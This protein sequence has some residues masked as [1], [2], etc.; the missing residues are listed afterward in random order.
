VEQEVLTFRVCDPAM[1]SG[2]FLVNAAHTITNFLVETLNLTPWENPGLDANPVTWRRKVA[3]RCLYG[4]D[5]NELAVELAKLS[6]WLT[7]VAK[8][9]PLSFLDHHLRHGN[10]LIG[11]RL[12]DLIEVLSSETGQDQASANGQ[13]SMFEEYPAF[14]VPL[15]EALDLMRDISARLADAAEDVESQAADYEQVRHRLKTF[16]DLAE[17][18]TAQ[19]CGLDV[20]QDRLHRIAHLLLGEE[21]AL[22]GD[23]RTLLSK[24]RKLAGRQEFFHWPLELPEVFIRP[25]QL[26][27]TVA[28]FDV[29]VGNPPHGAVAAAEVQ[30]YMAERFQV[31]RD[32]AV[33]FLELSSQ[34]TSDNGY[35]S[36]VMP[37]SMLFSQSWSSVRE[38]LFKEDLQPMAVLDA[39]R[40]FEGT[41]HEQSIIV[42]QKGKRATPGDIFVGYCGAEAKGAY[43][44]AALV[45]RLDMFPCSLAEDGLKVAES[46]LESA[47]GGV[48]RAWRGLPKR[49][50]SSTG[51]LA[52]SHQQ[53]ER[54]H[55][56]EPSQRI[57]L[58]ECSESSVDR[59]RTEKLVARRLMKRTVIPEPQVIVTCVPDRDGK[60]TFETVENIR[61]AT[62]RGFTTLMALC[63]VLNSQFVRW[64]V[65]N[66]VYIRPQTSMDFDECYINKIPIPSRLSSGLDEEHAS[67]SPKK[68]DLIDDWLISMTRNDHEGAEQSGLSELKVN[69]NEL[70]LE[71]ALDDVLSGALAFLASRIIEFHE[72]QVELVPEVDLLRYVESNQPLIRLDE[73]F[74]LHDGR[75]FDEVMKLES[76]HHD[77]DD[78]RLVPNEDATWTLELQ[79]KFRDP[80]Q[81]WRDWIKEEDGRLIKRQWVPAY[82]LRMSEEKA[83][84]YRYA[85]PR[86]QDFDNASSFPGGF[87]RSTL[88]KLHLTKVPILPD[89]DLS[90]LA[91]LD[92]ELS[93]TR[94]KIALTDDLIDQIVYKLYGLTEEE[95]A[96]VEGRA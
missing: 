59:L 3:K 8:G 42:F 47:R 86:L 11:A 14:R 33:D 15:M 67:L 63:A 95:I 32:S 65:N 85:L 69:Q 29:V 4:V 73:A 25:I 84:F 39:G 75:L 49:Y 89:V 90:E 41:S 82:R 30:N 13:L 23:D 10:S 88:K 77:I 36:F 60:L 93:E 6:L 79:A 50:A 81:G 20:D 72:T 28:A 55:A 54:Y 31:H 38:W 96:I 43:A 68:K 71:L 56:G 78:L 61:L 48:F 91:R 24:A 21:P 37:K 12:E 83:R 57:E 16:R 22:A 19:H 27:G 1:G 34:I 52:L 64:W 7:T 62:S 35:I 2:H 58:K 46:V 26:D 87:T 40:E 45:R 74:P 92:R 9:K 5:L 66:L 76:V 51:E 80:E 53:I 44:G 18:V 70:G 17:L 94:R